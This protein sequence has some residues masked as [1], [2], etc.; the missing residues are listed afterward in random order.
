MDSELTRWFVG[1]K[2]RRW[3]AFIRQVIIESGTTKTSGEPNITA[4]YDKFCSS[5]EGSGLRLA[6]ASFANY[7]KKA[8]PSRD[9][10]PESIEAIAVMLSAAKRER[11]TVAQLH[12]LI[13]RP[14]ASDV[15]S[16][17][18]DADLPAAAPELEAEEVLRS[19]QS[20]SI[21]ARAMIVPQILRLLAIDWAFV[22]MD[23]HQ[24]IGH[25]L[26]AEVATKGMG[27][28]AW[29]RKYLAEIPIDTL[30]LI[31]DGVPLPSPLT[32][33]QITG[34]QRAVRSIDGGTISAAELA[35]L[36]PSTA[37][38]GGKP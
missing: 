7:A 26:K 1:S 38:I 22:E 3:T 33:P 15:E 16:E 32:G 9:P 12:S 20:L 28:E 11:I 25:Q 30:R 8:G 6:R 35:A 10:F 31:A 29:G 4:F 37:S 14:V 23:L 24:Q 18:A 34:F 19:L 5:L 17:L 36:S 13:D 27:L 2:Y 21:D